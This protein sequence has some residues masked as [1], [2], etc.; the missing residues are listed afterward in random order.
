MK[1]KLIDLIS[2]S[3]FES[4]MRALKALADKLGLRL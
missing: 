3:K 4:S 2:E 1:F